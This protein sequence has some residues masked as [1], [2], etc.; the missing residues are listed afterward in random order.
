M[1]RR[2][3]GPCH[4]L[5]HDEEEHPLPVVLDRGTLEVTRRNLVPG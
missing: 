4:F 2:V 5:Q 1:G 3:E